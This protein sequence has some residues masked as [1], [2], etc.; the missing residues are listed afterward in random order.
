MQFTKRGSVSIHADFVG[1]S[2]AIRRNS[3]LSPLTA[4]RKKN[5]APCY[6][7]R[8]EPKSPLYHPYSRPPKKENSHR[9]TPSFRRYVA[10]TPSTTLK[11]AQFAPIF[12]SLTGLQSET[13]ALLSFSV[14]QPRTHSLLKE[15]LKSPNFFI[16]FVQ[17]YNKLYPISRKKSTILRLFSKET[18]SRF[19]TPHRS[20]LSA[21]QTPRQSPPNKATIGTSPSPRRRTTPRD[22][23]KTAKRNKTARTPRKS[24]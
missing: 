7:A 21:A 24:P 3:L 16:A 5:F 14:F 13:A 19:L 18:E 6:Q 22:P 11:T 10:H 1:N 8:G 15:T 23:T 12:S 2:R 9:Q 4:F 17:F 20:P